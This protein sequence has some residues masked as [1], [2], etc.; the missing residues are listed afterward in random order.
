MGRTKE[1]PRYNVVS[2]RISDDEL[3][4]ITEHVAR[5]KQPR[6]TVLRELV[7]AG[8]LN[9]VEEHAELR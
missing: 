2:F 5:S 9:Q 8:V 7:L 1:K 3:V 4:R 6:G